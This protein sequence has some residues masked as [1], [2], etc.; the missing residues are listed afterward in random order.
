MYLTGWFNCSFS[1]PFASV[2]NL[3]TSFSIF[4]NLFPICSLLRSTFSQKWLKG[5][6]RP[7]KLFPHSFLIKRAERIQGLFWNILDPSGT[8]A[9]LMEVFIV[10]IYRFKKGNPRA[11]VGLVETVGK[12]GRLGFTTMDELW[13][14]LNSSMGGERE[15]DAGGSLDL[16]KKRRFSWIPMSF[17]FTDPSP[18]CL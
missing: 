15:R 8:G 4:L 2:S 16:G 3:L 11:L 9:D 13:G 14:I 12:K 18:T 6:K 10:R 5:K 17:A 1:L 7:K